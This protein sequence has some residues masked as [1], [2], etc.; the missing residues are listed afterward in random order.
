MRIMRQLFL[1]VSDLEPTQEL[2]LNRIVTVT[3]IED[4]Y[5]EPTQ[6]LYLNPLKVTVLPLATF[7]EPTQ[8][9]YLNY[10][11]RGNTATANCSR[12]DTRVVFK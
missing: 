10:N 9:L 6:E 8:E 7:L 11:G 1:F 5:L 4:N 12:T 2:Y 3:S